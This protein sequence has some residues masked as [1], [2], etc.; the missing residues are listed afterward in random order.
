[1]PKSNEMFQANDQQG[2]LNSGQSYQNQQ[3]QGFKPQ[4]Y[5]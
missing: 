5:V 3:H 4:G 1:M 2:K